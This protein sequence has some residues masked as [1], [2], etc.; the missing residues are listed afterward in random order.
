MDK[1]DIN[2]MVYMSN[3]P[4]TVLFFVTLGILSNYS[5]QLLSCDVQTLFDTNMYAKHILGFLTVLFFNVMED[6]SENANEIHVY[7]LQSLIL[8]LWFVMLTRT[9]IV[10]AIGIISMV[11]A[12]YIIDARARKPRPGDNV[13]KIK[14]ASSVLRWV[15]L[16]VTFVGMLHYL[17]L[18]RLEYGKDF[19]IIRFIVGTPNCRRN[20]PILDL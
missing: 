2:S 4:V 14:L 19:S 3:L 1:N 16:G 11:V 17:W 12:I 18:K 10:V 8:Y 6:A 9:H 7:I 13:K 20:S 5:G 15:T